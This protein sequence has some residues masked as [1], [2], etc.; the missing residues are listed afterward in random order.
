MRTQVRKKQLIPGTQLFRNWAP[1]FV[2][3][4]KRMQQNDRKPAAPYL[5]EELDIVAANLHL[6]G[7]G[8]LPHPSYLPP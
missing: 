5:V 3:N 1:E 7:S 4:W 8:Y 2:V 6:Q